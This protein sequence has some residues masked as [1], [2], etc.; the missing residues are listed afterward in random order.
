VKTEAAPLASSSPTVT[1]SS[2]F[3]L[4]CTD[5][6]NFHVEDCWWPDEVTF[7]RSSEEIFRKYTDGK[8]RKEVKNEEG[9]VIL[10]EAGQ[11]EV[12]GINQ[13]FQDNQDLQN[14]QE[15]QSPIFKCLE[16]LEV[17]IDQE[18]EASPVVDGRRSRQVEK[19]A[20]RMLKNIAK[21]RGEVQNFQQVT[22]LAKYNITILEGLEQ[23]RRP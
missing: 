3:V 17:G 4:A 2:R 8:W 1:S 12:D 13:N 5:P 22:S 6:R 11:C 18:L 23:T 14:L 21:V 19:D 9:K 10:I 15:V 7:Y 16:E 20:R